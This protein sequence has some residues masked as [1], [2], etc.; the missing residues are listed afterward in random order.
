MR[1]KLIHA[2]RVVAALFALGV[3]VAACGESATQPTLATSAPTAAPATAAPATPVAATAAAAPATPAAAALQR[4]WPGQPA[5]IP[6]YG[7]IPNAPTRAP[8]PTLAPGATP[9]PTALPAIPPAPRV[10]PLYAHVDTVS[11]GPA[12]SK[13]NVDPNISCVKTSVFSRGQRIVWRMELVD[14]TAG[15]ILQGADVRDAALKLPNGEEV[16]F[17]YGRH[18]TTQDAPWFWTA[19]WDI[20]LDHPLGT[21]DYSITVSAVSGKS[22]TFQ[23]PLTM[24]LPARQMDTRVQIVN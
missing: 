22:M 24:T 5:Q 4:P 23:D 7:A 3:L 15:R 17:R 10:V 6:I 8:A 1:S 20:P 12:E 19:A 13:Y 21:V 18:G 14:T 16:K 11:A 9:A 2:G